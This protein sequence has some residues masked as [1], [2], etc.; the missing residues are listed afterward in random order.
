MSDNE[1]PEPQQQPSPPEGQP[2]AGEPAA[3][4]PAFISA[5]FVCRFCRKGRLDPAGKKPGEDM[6]CPQCGKLTKVTLE[7]T[8]GE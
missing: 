3:D 2:P 1:I 6:A 5:F 8:L 4:T 7:H